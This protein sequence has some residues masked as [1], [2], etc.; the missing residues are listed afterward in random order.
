MKEELKTVRGKR[1][2]ICVSQSANYHAIREKA[3]SKWCAF[4]R[5][6]DSTKSY[7][8]LLEDGSEARFM[9]GKCTGIG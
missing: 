5:S 3:I 6:F 2:P 9:P 8:L 1:L 7:V 4:G